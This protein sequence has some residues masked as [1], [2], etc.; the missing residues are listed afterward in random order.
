LFV[1]LGATET[2]KLK[3][4]KIFFFIAF[5]GIATHALNAQNILILEK[6][7]TKK[8]TTFKSG[9]FIR[10][11]LKDQDHYLQDHIVSVKDSSLVFHY[12][13]V[14]INEIEAIDISKKRFAP[15][16]LKKIGTLMQVVGIGYIAIDNLNRY[17]VQ[18]EEY[19]FDESV[20]ILGGSLFVAGTGMK[21]LRP[22]KFKVGG[23]FR[24]RVIDINYL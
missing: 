15:I 11:K 13:K 21:L 5:I 2:K 4:K 10:Y 23:R 12:N 8:K 24:I 19:E 18:G 14:S 6:T 22:R 17:V 3:A 20:W 9:D 7:G 16:D 1:L